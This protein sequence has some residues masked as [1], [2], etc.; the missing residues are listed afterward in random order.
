MNLSPPQ[1]QLKRLQSIGITVQT[2]NSQ[3]YLKMHHTQYD[4]VDQL[5]SESSHQETKIQVA[6]MPEADFLSL[7]KSKRG[8]QKM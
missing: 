4:G 2:H 6:F 8:P 5:V 1:V 7:E 3:D